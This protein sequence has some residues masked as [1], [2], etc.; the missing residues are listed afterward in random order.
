MQ[1]RHEFSLYMDKTAI[2]ERRGT[3]EEEKESLLIIILLYCSGE[4]V[5]VDFNVDCS[6]FC[7]IVVV[8]RLIQ[9]E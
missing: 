7:S 3:T 4:D 9:T 8:V 5:D 1:A 6:W 2:H